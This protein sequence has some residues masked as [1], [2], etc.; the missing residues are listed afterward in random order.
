MDLDAHQYRTRLYREAQERKK[1]AI[2]DLVMIFI[3]LISFGFPG[4]YKLL[5]GNSMGMLMEY[6]A[7]LM[8]I[9]LMLVS[10]ADSVLDVKIINLKGKYRGIYMLMAVISVCSIYIVKDRRSEIII[11]CIRL[12]TTALYAIW[13]SENLSVK[14]ILELVYWTE[15]MFTAASVF[16]MFADEDG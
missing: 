6:A 10:N 8:E 11:S 14:K 7:F 5:I 4:K 16:F 2:M 1:N 15:I 12:T 9:G 13:L 3:F